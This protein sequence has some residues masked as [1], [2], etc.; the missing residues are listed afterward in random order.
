MT[1]EKSKNASIR[2]RKEEPGN[3][4]GTVRGEIQVPGRKTGKR[5]RKSNRAR[6]SDQRSPRH[7][8][9]HV[10]QKQR[11]PDQLGSRN[12]SKPSGHSGLDV[13]NLRDQIKSTNAVDLLQLLAQQEKLL[14]RNILIRKDKESYILFNLYT[15]RP[16]QD[17]YEIY[18]NNEFVDYCINK[19]IAAAW[20]IADHYQ[21]VN[22]SLKLRRLNNEYNRITN[23]IN[24]EFNRVTANQ[25][26]QELLE[27]RLSRDKSRKKDIQAE[28]DILIDQA[29]YIQNKGFNNETSRTH[30]SAT[31]KKRR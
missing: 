11:S 5:G 16:W 10:S 8:D 18:K 28:L 15:I 7:S 26:L 4:R 9:G 2:H 27:A 19:K 6:N 17:A 22:L 25:D 29:K 12:N 23:R 21:A 30:T 14:P 1:K 13:G 24:T 3:P 31:G 20:C